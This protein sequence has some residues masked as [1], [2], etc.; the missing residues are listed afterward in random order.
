MSQQTLVV[1]MF[2]HSGV[3]SSPP[4]D[5]HSN[6]EEFCAIIYGLASHDVQRLGLDT[7]FFRKGR[8]SWELQTKELLG[9]TKRRK[10]KYTILT[11]LYHIPYI[12]GR[13]TKCFAAINEGDGKRYVIKDCWVSVD[14]LEGKESEASLLT[15]ARACGISKGIPLIRHSEEV[16]VR[17]AGRERPDTVLNNRR[18]TSSDNLN[19]ERIHTRLVISP[20]GKPLD[21]FSN[22]KELL[23][24]YYDALQGEFL[25]CLC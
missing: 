14:K 22:R 9:R 20:Y 13:R 2:D 25:G 23:L 1:H 8:A 11:T 4:L 7:S 5:Y 6:P 24:A 19:L 18:L 3:I 17:E 10:V 21:R 16:H 15:H 12:I